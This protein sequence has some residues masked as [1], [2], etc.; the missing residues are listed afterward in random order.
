MKWIIHT[1]Q[2]KVLL[3]DYSVNDKNLTSPSDTYCVSSQSHASP[4]TLHP[5]T[6]V[7]IVPLSVLIIPQLLFV[8]LHL[9]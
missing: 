8:D 6:E 7:T 4:F 3:R 2:L 5:Q 9:P 1:A